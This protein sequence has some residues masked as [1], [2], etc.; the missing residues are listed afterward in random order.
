MLDTTTQA[1]A[2]RLAHYFE[3]IGELL[4]AVG[5]ESAISMSVDNYDALKVVWVATSPLG[6]ISQVEQRFHF[7]ALINASDQAIEYAAR[8]FSDSLINCTFPGGLKA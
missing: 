8:R 1:L 7:D 6:D 2:D 4:H 5:Y 3:P